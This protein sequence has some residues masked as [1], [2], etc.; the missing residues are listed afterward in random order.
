MAEPDYTFQA[1]WLAQ[2][3]SLDRAQRPL[4]G[5]PSGP[6][7]GGMEARI[8]K[9]E[10]HVGHIQSDIADIKTDVREIRNERHSDVRW[11]IGFYIGGV[12]ALVGLM[13]KGFGWL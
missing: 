8:A 9:L 2:Q 6:H 11:A 4:E 7:D 5:G 12:V 3:A 13:A 1:Q 10:A